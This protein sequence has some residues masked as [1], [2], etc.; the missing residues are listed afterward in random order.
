MSPYSKK[1]PHLDRLLKRA[2]PVTLD[3][4]SK[5]LVLSDLHMGNGGRLDEFRQNSELVKTMLERYYLPEQ[6]S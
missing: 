2:M 4:S 5:V 1:H 6:Y 3:H